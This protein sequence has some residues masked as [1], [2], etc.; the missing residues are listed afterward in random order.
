[1]LDPVA[2]YAT[3]YRR[4]ATRGLLALKPTIIR[5]NASEIIALAGGAG[6]G[7]GVDSGDSVEFAEQS[8]ILLARQYDV[9]VAVTGEIDFVTDGLHSVHIRGGSALMPKITALGCSLTCLVGAFAAIRPE[10]PFDATIAALA[11]FAAAGTEA[12]KLA[13]GPGSFQWRLLDALAALDPRRTRCHGD[14]CMKTFDL[15]LYLVLDPDL[16]AGYGVVETARAAVEGGATIVQLRDKTG[17]TA[18]LI[19]TGRA[20]KS[21]L[22]RHRRLPGRQ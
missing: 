5:A 6:A 10:A 17:G 4:E 2:H 18:R 20:L 22:A 7:K 3:G 14:G 19:E 11:T 15:S 8:A 13:D 1:M 21:A 16:C 12:E 9:V